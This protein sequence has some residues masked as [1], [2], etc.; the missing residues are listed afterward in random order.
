MK[1]VFSLT[2]AVALLASAPALANGGKIDVMTQ[3]QYLGADLTP[4]IAAPGPVEFNEALIAAL[5]EIASND[6]PA[7][8]EKLADLIANR[9]PDI[10]GL[11][12]MFQFRCFETGFLPGACDDPSIAN[13]FNDHLQLTL[14]A[15]AELE[16]PYVDVATVN[17]L[18]LTSP[19][20]PG[21]P[22]GLPVDLNFDTLPDITVTVLD[23]DVVLVQADHA[24][25]AAPVDFTPFQP[26][27]I[28][29]KP[30]VDGCNYTVVASAESP[31]GPIA[32]E[33]GFVGVDVAIDGTTYRFVDTHLE[34]QRPDPTDPLSPVFQSAQSVE[35]LQTL[36]AT[37]P[38]NVSLIVVGDINS[39]PEDPIIPGPLPLPPPF[40]EG[41]V[42]PYT[43]LV[44]AGYTDAWDLRPGAVPGYSCCQQ[45]DLSNHQSQ[46]R[47]R[48]DVLFSK[49][50]PTK[51]KKARVLGAKVS[52]KTSPP[53][54]G[55]WPSDHGSVAAELEFE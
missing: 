14:D 35:L 33:R 55:L 20:M 19:V 16:E 38:P 52:D 23:R 17:N 46:L 37:T 48:I 2:V 11:Q 28:C 39:S 44:A 15:L 5:Q 6:Y 10:A 24:L 49:E 36:G 26:F 43:Q 12:E 53:G 22:P 54:H 8:A 4:I 3:N 1:F 34:V 21:L 30:S 50:A 40:D 47:E 27:G 7:R 45:G 9:L 42:P 13:A 32:I 25:N 41:I 51:V 29:T 18:D 31:I